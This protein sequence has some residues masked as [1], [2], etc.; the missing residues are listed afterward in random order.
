MFARKSRLAWKISS[1]QI[2]YHFL[3][4]NNMLRTAAPVQSVSESHDSH[5]QTASSSEGQLNFQRSTFAVSSSSNHPTVLSDVP[6]DS[7]SRPIEAKYTISSSVIESNSPRGNHPAGLLDCPPVTSERPSIQQALKEGKFDT[8]R[9]LR[10]AGEPLPDQ[11]RPEASFDRTEDY[12]SHLVRHPDQLYIALAQDQSGQLANKQ[13]D[14]GKTI[15]HHLARYT[16]PREDISRG[17][18]VLSSVE[19]LDLYKKDK[20]GNTPIHAALWNSTSSS[21]IRNNNCIRD[22]GWPGLLN[23]AKTRNFDFRTTGEDGLTVLQIATLA[24]TTTL[25]HVLATVS[26]PAI[27]ALSSDGLT[28]LGY[29]IQSGKANAVKTLIAAGAKTD[30]PGDAD[31]KPSMLLETA[32]KTLELYLEHPDVVQS[33]QKWLA[34]LVALRPLVAVNRAVPESNARVL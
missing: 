6:K 21:C 19:N 9:E 23:E 34:E 27:D 25:G 2:R 30:V 32:I 20:H 5:Q 33:W 12:F 14:N 31:K 11:T 22:T 15:A 10:N 4:K 7:G 17:L 29:A 26:D 3:E 24:D 8:V 13:D 1:H 28:A 18:K 16:G